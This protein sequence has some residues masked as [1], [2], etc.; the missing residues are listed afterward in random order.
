[1]EAERPVGHAALEDRGAEVAQVLLAGRAPAAEPA[2][3]DER[4]HDV[5]ARL[6]PAHARPD[7]LDDA[8]ALMAADE[9]EAG[10]DVAVAEVLVGVAQPGR[11]IADEHLTLLGGS[12][13]S[14]TTSQ[15]APSSRSTPPLSSVGLLSFPRPQ[16]YPSL[17]PR[18]S[19]SSRG[20]ASRPRPPAPISAGRAGPRVARGAPRGAP[21]AA[22]GA[23][24]APRARRRWSARASR[25][26]RSP[27]RPRSPAR[28]QR[29]DHLTGL[30]AHRSARKAPAS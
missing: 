9:R 29:P 10:N 8:G 26:P 13:S 25:S 20:G 27:R 19:S 30:G 4:A 22:S 11:D 5:V 7:L 17:R 16:P 23:P 1:M 24:R 14:S 6:D 2:G 18:T 15:S 28:E 12:R 21:G 3:R